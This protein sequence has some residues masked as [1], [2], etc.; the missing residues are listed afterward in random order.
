MRNI[1]P[2]LLLRLGHAIQHTKFDSIISASTHDKADVG[3]QDP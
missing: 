2:A 1:S 3:Q